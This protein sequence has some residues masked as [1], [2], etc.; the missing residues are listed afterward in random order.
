MF[1]CISV[2]VFVQVLCAETVTV[3]HPDGTDYS[4]TDSNSRGR[5]SAGAGLDSNYGSISATLEQFYGAG[6]SDGYLQYNDQ[7][8]D[9]KAS[10]S[11]GHTKGVVAF[12]GDGG[13][14]SWQW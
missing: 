10:G 12:D 8:P 7:T 5:F 14:W 1:V 3:Q 13:Y 2:W 11:K 6:S 4:Y 9:G